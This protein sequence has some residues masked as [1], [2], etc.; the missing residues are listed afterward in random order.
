MVCM[1]ELM[2]SKICEQ[3]G[4]NKNVDLN[5]DSGWLSTICA[6]CVI[7]KKDSNAN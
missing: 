2:S 5:S 1:T 4:T 3:C 6:E 7:D